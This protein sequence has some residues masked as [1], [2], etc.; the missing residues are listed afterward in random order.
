MI[1]NDLFIL[2]FRKTDDSYHTLEW[3]RVVLAE[4]CL[5]VSCCFLP[6]KLGGS[7]LAAINMALSAVNL[8]ECAGDALSVA[9]L[10]EIYVSAALRIKT[11]LPRGLHYI[12]VSLDGNQY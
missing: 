10:S 2:E 8:A 3:I 11:S 7:H 12:S 5:N 1:W 4:L 9:T 6:G